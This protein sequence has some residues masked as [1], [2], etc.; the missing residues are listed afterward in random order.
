MWM[1]AKTAQRI[2][3]SAS[4]AILMTTVPVRVL[5]VATK[6]NCAASVGGFLGFPTWYKYLEPAVSAGECT[7]KFDIQEDVPKVLL[8]VFEIILRVG[9]L[10][11]VGFIIYGGF[12]YILSQG[13]PDNAKAA[14]STILNALIGLVITMSSVVIVNLIGKNI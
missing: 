5:A 13:N 8:A 7:I 10:I 11:A 12:Q 3:L 6:D 2:K 9:G 4:M 1:K 14:R